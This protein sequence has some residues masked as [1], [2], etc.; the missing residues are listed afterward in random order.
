MERLEFRW[1]SCGV[2]QLCEVER[3]EVRLLEPL[4]GGR[5]E[6]ACRAPLWVASGGEAARG[7]LAAVQLI[8]RE[9][10]EA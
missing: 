7:T 2:E 4:C 9:R 3:L 10:C 1:S 8:A 5:R 6:A